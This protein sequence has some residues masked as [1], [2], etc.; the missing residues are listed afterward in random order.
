MFE[1]CKAEI[2]SAAAVRELAVAEAGFRYYQ[3]AI[4]RLDLDEAVLAEAIDLA[5]YL[6]QQRLADK[7]KNLKRDL[8]IPYEVLLDESEDL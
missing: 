6:R 5:T 3:A 2:T 4:K 8:V 7:L 1:R